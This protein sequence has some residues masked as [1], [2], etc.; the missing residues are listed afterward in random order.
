[1]RLIVLA[2]SVALAAAHPPFTHPDWA[3]Q[4]H[5]TNPAVQ[6]YW[7]G[8]PG[9]AACISAADAS[10]IATSF[11]LTISNY[12]EALAVQLFTNNFTDQSDSVNT[13]IHEP[14]LKATDVRTSVLGNY[15]L[16]DTNKMSAWVFDLLLESRVPRRPRSPA[17]RSLQDS[18]PLEY[19]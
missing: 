8:P 2:A 12:T 13:L 16:R 9:D 19:L 4:P 3:P 7:H 14:G 5:P 17:S 11:G 15:K 18:E 1:M 10:L 6:P